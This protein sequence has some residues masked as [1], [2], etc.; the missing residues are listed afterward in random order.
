MQMREED[1]GSDQ[2]DHTLFAMSD[3]NKS[4]PLVVTMR[5]NLADLEM[6]VDTGV[7][8]NQRNNIP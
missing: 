2:S 1:R 6:E 8:F 7:I 5:A 3:S 4:V